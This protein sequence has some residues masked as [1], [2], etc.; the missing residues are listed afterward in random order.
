[1]STQNNHLPPN[2]PQHLKDVDL[3]GQFF[4]YEVSKPHKTFYYI[5]TLTIPE[6]EISRS[7]YLF[8]KDLK[9]RRIERLHRQ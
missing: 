4:I 9:D 7:E 1:M 3:N 5:K 6:K 2:L 8:L